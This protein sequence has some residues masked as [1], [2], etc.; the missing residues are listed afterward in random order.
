MGPTYQI[1]I[2][3]GNRHFVLKH[4]LEALQRIVSGLGA[5]AYPLFLR[6]GSAPL[7]RMHPVTVRALLAEIEHFTQPLGDLTVPTLLFLDEQDLA[8]GGIYAYEDPTALPESATMML[9][10]TSEGIRIIMR[11]VPPPVGFRSSPGLKSGTYECYFASVR[12]QGEGYSGVRT[13]AMG[14]SNA[15]VALPGLTLPPVT[16]WDFAR[17]SGAPTIHAIRCQQQ[18]A[19]DVFKDVLHTVTSSCEEALRLRTALSIRLA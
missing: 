17:V 13:A 11:Q 16:R 5:D 2:E 19:P 18:P 3:G 10:P 6:L 8:M 1:Q 15:P 12:L 9:V 7:I 4:Q 14:G